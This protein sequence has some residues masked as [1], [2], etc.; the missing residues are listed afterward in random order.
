MD[1]KSLDL[2]ALGTLGEVRGDMSDTS[3]GEIGRGCRLEEHG[4]F[5]TCHRRINTAGHFVASG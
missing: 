2:M 3:L 4:L 1:E 5:E